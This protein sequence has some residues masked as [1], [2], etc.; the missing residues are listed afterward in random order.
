MTRYGARFYPKIYVQVRGSAASSNILSSL[1]GPH[2]FRE[3]VNDSIITRFHILR[4]APRLRTPT[5]DTLITVH[6]FPA[7]SDTND[8][9]IMPTGSYVSFSGSLVELKL[10]YIQPIPLFRMQDAVQAS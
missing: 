1:L 10:S 2:R 6:S 9:L 8:I 7:C 5:T 4:E 3:P